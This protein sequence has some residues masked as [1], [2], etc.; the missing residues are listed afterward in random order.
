MQIKT[1]MKKC[2]TATR[3]AIIKTQAI[4]RVGDDMEKLEPA[5]QWTRKAPEVEENEEREFHATT[6]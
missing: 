6:M 2:F 5:D 4:T 1:T 3:M